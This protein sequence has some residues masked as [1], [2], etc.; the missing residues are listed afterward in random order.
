MKI[1][2][3]FS[4]Q[5]I[6]SRNSNELKDKWEVSNEFDRVLQNHI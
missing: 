5:E 2:E 1:R 6:N 4:S 3:L